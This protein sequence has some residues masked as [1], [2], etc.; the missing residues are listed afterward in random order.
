MEELMEG[1]VSDENFFPKQQ[2]DTQKDL[3]NY[4]RDYI[5][6]KSEEL[7][8]SKINRTNEQAYK[9][10]QEKS[11]VISSITENLKTIFHF[12]GKEIDD[13]DPRFEI[14]KPII[15]TLNEA[16]KEDLRALDGVLKDIIN[17]GNDE[18]YMKEKENIPEGELKDNNYVQYLLAKELYSANQTTEGR[19]NRV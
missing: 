10:K 7:I 5:K 4:M 2:Y 1:I 8:F 6:N 12:N 18:D 15:Y 16:S 11:V 14:M 3:D 17:K 13:K 19:T 9:E